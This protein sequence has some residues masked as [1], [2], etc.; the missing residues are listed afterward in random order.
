MQARME[1][2]EGMSIE[3][4]H[5]ALVRFVEKSYGSQGI[6][7]LADALA[8]EVVEEVYEQ[9]HQQGFPNFPDL[10]RRIENLGGLA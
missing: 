3:S 5:E 1:V 4:A 10:R 7:A 8:L 6:L 9:V 2:R